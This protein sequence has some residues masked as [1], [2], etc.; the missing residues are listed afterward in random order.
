[1]S[2]FVVVFFLLSLPR[3]IFTTLLE[4]FFSHSEFTVLLKK[5]LP[6]AFEFS[7]TLTQTTKEFLSNFRTEFSGRFHLHL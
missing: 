6:V 2:F 1:M 4:S 5:I 7:V 3:L